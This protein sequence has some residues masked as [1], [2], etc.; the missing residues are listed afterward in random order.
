M[1]I[2]IHRAPGLS[3]FLLKLLVKLFL[4]YSSTSKLLLL[5]SRTS[6]KYHISQTDQYNSV[7]LMLTKLPHCYTKLKS[8]LKNLSIKILKT[9]VNNVNKNHTFTFFNLEM[10]YP[11]SDET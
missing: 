11:Q 8:L 3:R 7:E 4:S 10:F 1:T 5:T 9:V 2:M 6:E